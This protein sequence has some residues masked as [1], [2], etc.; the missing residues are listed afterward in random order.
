MTVKSRGVAIERAF[1]VNGELP[2]QN[3]S[4]MTFLRMWADASEPRVDN[5]GNE[6]RPT[7]TEVY[8]WQSTYLKDKMGYVS[9]PYQ[10]YFEKGKNTI[11]LEAVNEPMVLRKLDIVAVE[12]EFK[13]ADYTAAQTRGRIRQ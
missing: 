12:D 7:Q 9:E 3:A 11:T 6:I 2:F 13:Y 10:F 1:Y 8:G 5:R 4:D